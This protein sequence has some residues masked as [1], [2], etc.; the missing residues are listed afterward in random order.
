MLIKVFSV[1]ENMRY[2]M[3]KKKLGTLNYSLDLSRLKVSCDT[4][5]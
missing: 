1:K 4:L 5:I 3:A 2:G